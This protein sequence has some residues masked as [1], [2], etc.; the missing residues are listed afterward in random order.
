MLISFVEPSLWIGT[1]LASLFLSGNIPSLN[2]VF[3]ISLKVKEMCSLAI[4][5]SLIGIDEGPDDLESSS[6][7]I[8]S[9]ISLGVEWYNDIEEGILGGR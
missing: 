9:L 8:I 4:F 3:H 5:N 1:T 2:E 6:E 7:E